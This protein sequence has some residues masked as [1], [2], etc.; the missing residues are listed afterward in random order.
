MKKKLSLLLAAAMLTSSL[1]AMTGVNAAFSDVAENNS[2]KKAITTL[3]KLNVINGYDD[4]T[5]GPEKDITRAEFTKII[6]SMLGY[7]ELS[8]KTTQFED[9]SEDHWANANIKTA[10]DLGIINGYSD[11]EFRPD[12]PVTYEQALKMVVCTLGYQSDAEAKGG[13]PEGYRAEAVTLNL[14][15]KISGVE[16]TSNAPRGVIAQVMYNSL[17]IKLREKNGSK[18]QNTTKTLLNDYLNVYKLKGTVVGVEESTTSACDNKLY[19]GQLAIDEDSSNTEY[20]IDFTEYASSST[21]MT[22]YIGQLVQIYYR[23]DDDDLFLTEIDDE[24]YTNK[25]LT[26]N[27]YDISDYTDL[28]LKY[29]PDDNS[30][31]VSIKFDKSDFT[32]RYNGRAVTENVDI[33]GSSYTP[34]E[35]L[36]QWLDPESDFFIYG[37]A[38]VIDSGADGSYNIIDIYDYDTLVALS[39]PTDPDYLISDKT[40]ASNSLILNPEDSDYKM[41]VTRDGKEI[42]VT[43]ISAGDVLTYATSLEGD[44][45]TV[46]V[47]K[48]S[49]SGTITSLN[50]DSELKSNWTISIDNKK[51]HVNERFL[52]Y[53]ALKEQKTLEVGVNITGYL[54][55]LGAL[56]W[57]TITKSTSYFPY[58]YVVNASEENEDVYLKLYAPTNKSLTSF[59]SSTAYKVQKFKIQT[60]KPKLN[61]TK[62]SPSAIKSALHEN[63]KSCNPDADIA[64]ISGVKL[65]GYNQLIRVGFNSSGQ[66]SEVITISTEYDGIPNDDANYLVRYKAMNPASKYYVTSSSVKE[67]SSGSNLYMINSSTPLFVIPKDRSN[68]DAYSLKSAITTNSMVSGNEYYVESYDLTTKKYPTLLLVYNTTFKSGTGI[69]YSTAYRLLA[70]DIEQ[71]YSEEDNDTY[72]MLHTYNSAT[73]ITDTKI[74]S[75]AEYLFADL[76]KGDIILNGTDG[77]KMADS[78]MLAVD[79]DDIQRILNGEQTPIRD[80]EGE[81]IGS[82]IYNW[83]EEQEQTK[84][85]N[86]QKYVFDF[87]YPKKDQTEAS[88]NYYTTGGNATDISSRAFMCNVM[89]VL[90][91]DNMLYVTLDGFDELGLLN[92]NDFIQIKTS[93]ST[94]VVRYDKDEKEFTPYV[95]GT[96]KTALTVKDL[97]DAENYGI[98][99][100]KVLVTYVSG[101][102]SKSTSTPTAKFIVIYSE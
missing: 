92:E 86:W 14:Q 71:E 73:T 101:S 68:A 30:K 16:Y 44:Y 27:S 17:E 78:V 64:N 49:V 43:S 96:E 93:S 20:V 56:E 84:D 10:Y 18:W 82:E 99:C 76:S 2:Y 31:A 48:E 89:Q 46:Y 74:A 35:A 45:Y 63:A 15:E 66:I 72:N 24:T 9:L 39:S 26:I 59:T 50:I 67:S 23:K 53:I 95:R 100:S 55:A 1:V 62:S 37:T 32:I 28:N 47:T 5:F 57:G 13:Y 98:N 4:G 97:K 85:N 21:Q 29:Y 102:T 91:D 58:A 19:P 33:D 94:K 51:Y 12:S 11:T 90:E 65:T 61:G 54:D 25:E 7:K 40:V 52:T 77:D 38:R 34:T 79:Y 22:P 70:K 69:T 6:V 75:E 88:D 8:T 80:E 83:R 41:S 87:R 36:K 81:I 60:S 42:S 3:S